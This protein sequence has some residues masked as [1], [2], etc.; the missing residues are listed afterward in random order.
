MRKINPWTKFFTADLIPDSDE[1]GNAFWGY[2]VANNIGR[3]LNLDGTVFFGAIGTSASKPSELYGISVAR[4]PIEMCEF[5]SAPVVQ[6]AAQVEIP[7]S[8]GTTK[9]Y[10]TWDGGQLVYNVGDTTNVIQA[11][12]DHWVFDEGEPYNN[13]FLRIGQVAS[14]VMQIEGYY[15]TPVNGSYVVYRKSANI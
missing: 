11:V 4:I 13:N 12:Y 7:E 10:G 6:L 9:F 2:H 15:V 5:R 3:L 8:S 14:E 1:I